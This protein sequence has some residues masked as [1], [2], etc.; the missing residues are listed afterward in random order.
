[1]MVS[2]SGASGENDLREKLGF[3]PAEI[4]INSDQMSFPVTRLR[5]MRQ[6]D[7]LRSLVRE[8]RLTPTGF[9]YPLFVCPGEGVRKEISSMPGVFNISVDEAV[10][11]AREAKSLGVG[12]IILFGLPEKKDDVATGAWA[13]DGIVQ[14]ATRAI[15]RE[16]RDLVVVGDVCLC[17]YMS[18]GH[19]GIVQKKSA[20]GGNAAASKR[21]S[22][23]NG[24]RSAVAT[25]AAA[26]VEYEILNDPT[27]EILAKTAVSQARAGMDIIAP[28]D[29]MDGRVGA[30][31]KAL[32]QAGFLNT[33]ILSYAAKFASGFYGP[34]REAA[35]SA[36]QFGDRRS[37]QMDG[38]NIRE[39]MREI[40]L[41]IKEGADMI[42]VKPAMPYLDVISEARRRFDL[43]IAAYQVSG[44]YSMLQAAIAHGWLDRDRVII[45][46][47]TSIRRAGAQLILTYF[48]KDAARMLG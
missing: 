28:S 5:R 10:K 20:G 44:E 21:G 37:Y 16:V 48:A 45:E 34:F 12:G 39:A 3:N 1:M 4:L 11:E 47:L 15:K 35:D 25:Q 27:L 40:S 22:A 38:A 43:P 46:S 32:D 23:G 9:I 8:T 41:D 7:S 24:G 42:M 17:E 33:P 36:P 29:M 14:R 2:R 31:R 30:I 26:E 18:H 13:E 6:T 19:C